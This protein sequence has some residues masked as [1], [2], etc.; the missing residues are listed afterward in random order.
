M[1]VYDIEQLDRVF[2]EEVETFL[3]LSST[4]AHE[5]QDVQKV[6]LKGAAEAITREVLQGEGR[7][8]RAKAEEV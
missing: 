2:R 7:M 6:A 1:S 8:N 4:K 3:D 5:I